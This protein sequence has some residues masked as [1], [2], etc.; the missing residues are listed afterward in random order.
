MLSIF[1]KHSVQGKSNV[2]EIESLKNMD[3]LVPRD[4]KFLEL[5]YLELLTYREIGEEFGITTERARQ[6]TISAVKKLKKLNEKIT[7]N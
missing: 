4:Q 2:K 1:E 5:R 6:N 7:T 3:K